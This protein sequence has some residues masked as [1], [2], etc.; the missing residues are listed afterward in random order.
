MV[1]RVLNQKLT[2]SINYK[3]QH[4]LTFN[5][6]SLTKEL[7]E[8]KD[9][10]RTLTSQCSA[11]VHPLCPEAQSATSATHSMHFCWIFPELVLIIFIKRSNI[12][13]RGNRSGPYW[14]NE[15]IY[16]WL[17]YDHHLKRNILT[18]VQ[19]T[20]WLRYTPHEHLL[21]FVQN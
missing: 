18:K 19:E 7:G 15:S 11:N 8:Y 21:L 20:Y 13:I 4:N 14:K 2:Q 10:N 9:F 12:N 1:V 5:A 3:K 16:L 17:S 6:V